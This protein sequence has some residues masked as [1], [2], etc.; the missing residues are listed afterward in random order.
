MKKTKELFKDY[1]IEGYVL[2]RLG[3]GTTNAL[4]KLAR[5]EVLIVAPKCLHCWLKDLTLN[6]LISPQM[7]AKHPEALREEVLYL[8]WDS[9]CAAFL[10]RNGSE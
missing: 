10:S 5:R 3:Y 9:M 6:N 1:K 7:L 4:V 2:H 8:Y